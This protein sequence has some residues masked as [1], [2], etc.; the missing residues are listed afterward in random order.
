MN[1]IKFEPFYR[2]SNNYFNPFY[3]VEKN[4]ENYIDELKK[5]ISISLGEVISEKD[6][7]IEDFIYVV[8]LFLF[9]K[10][11]EVPNS[12]ISFVEIYDFF[13]NMGVNEDKILKFKIVNELKIIKELIEDMIKRSKLYNFYKVH[14][15]LKLNVLDKAICE[16]NEKIERLRNLGNDN[17]EQLKRE[18][19]N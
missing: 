16:V 3:Y 17:L 8:T 6:K 11:I 1:V 2:T 7:N 4:N 14:N 9:L 5:I 19:L 13:S 18:I 15:L 12:E 10:K